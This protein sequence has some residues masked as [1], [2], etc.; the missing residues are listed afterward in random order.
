MKF[1]FPADWTARGATFKPEEAIVFLEAKGLATGAWSWRD[2]WQEEHAAAFTIA[3]VLRQDL[4]GDVKTSLSKALADGQTFDQWRAEMR[5]V[6]SV[7][8]D[9]PDGSAEDWT[10]PVT[11]RDPKTGDLKEVDLTTV[12]RQRV[13]YDTNIRTASAAGEW[14]Q[15]EEAAELLPFLRYSAVLDDRTRPEHRA[16]HGVTLPVSDPFWRTHY[17]PCGW[18][19]RCLTEQLSKGQVDRTGGPSKPPALKPAEKVNSRTGESYLSY[20]GVDDGFASNPGL[21]RMSPI[22]AQNLVATG[23]AELKGPAPGAPA[24]P[25]PRRLPASA[26]LPAIDPANQEA[27]RNRIADFLD[28]LGG[29]AMPKPSGGGLAPR[30]VTDPIGQR[31]IIGEETFIKR[32]IGASKLLRDPA[33][34]RYLDLIARTMTDPDEIWIA[35]R[36][37]NQ[38][39]KRIV[40]AMR[41]HVAR[42]DIDDGSGKAESVLVALEIGRDGW[43]AVTGLKV[44]P[45]AIEAK[46]VGGLVYRRNE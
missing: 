46:R 38:N 26:L 13:I 6:L 21:A 24:L 45:D 15:I 27:V 35:M 16:W 41:H 9:R 29:E 1:S 30:L 33:R 19:C 23:F 10:K 7:K 20:P 37:A 39:G 2:I 42:F 8:R 25:T 5:Q 34:G 44:R 36:E 3:G 4:L 14:A 18:F 22:T 43:T 17:P 28:A 12:R 32:G 31:M 40:R 11:V